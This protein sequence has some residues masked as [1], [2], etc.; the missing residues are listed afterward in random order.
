MRMEE[1]VTRTQQMRNSYKILVLN[2][3]G[4]DLFG[5]RENNIKMDLTVMACED[6]N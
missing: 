5:N 2:L 6:M 3:K 1:L 4:G